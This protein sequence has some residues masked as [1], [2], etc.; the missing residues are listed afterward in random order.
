M[1]A[2][3][4]HSL[5]KPW[6]TTDGHVDS[7][8]K[9]RPTT[10]RDVDRLQKPRH[11]TA[12]HVHSL[13]KTWQTTA[14]DVDSLQNPWQTT[15]RDVDSLRK[16]WQTTA[17]H[18]HSLRKQWHTTAGH[19]DSLQIPLDIKSRNAAV[20][21]IPTH[22]E[23]FRS[24]DSM[25]KPDGLP[26]LSPGFQGTLG[27]DPRTRG[28]PRR[29]LRTGA[30]STS[31][32]TFGVGPLSTPPIPGFCKPWAELRKPFRLEPAGHVSLISRLLKPHAPRQGAM[33]LAK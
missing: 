8:R 6:H 24:A 27:H 4:D 9:P 1:T 10:V 22:G 31:A 30:P 11:T 14:R 23:T 28:Q 3:H 25:T 32:T 16:P 7:L 12:R 29:R 26:Y 2:W 17:R 18:A 21:D 33:S 13:Q 5:Q 15:A 20:S 19:V